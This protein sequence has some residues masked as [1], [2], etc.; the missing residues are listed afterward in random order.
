MSE[1]AP[2]VF[3]FYRFCLASVALVTIIIFRRQYFVFEKSKWLFLILLAILA[4]PLN[5]CLFLYGLNYTLPT[6]PALLYATTPIWVY[7]L[8]AWRREEKM[9]RGKTLGIFIA[10][11]GVVAFFMEKGLSMKMDY[12]FGDSLIMLAVW[13]WAIY[14]VLGRPL[15]QQKGVIAVTSTTLIL[16]T[17]MY[18]PFGLYL[19]LVF[20]YSRVSWIGWSAVAYTALLTS[21]LSYTIWYWSIKNMEPSRT[22]IFVN[23]QPVLTAFLAYFLLGERLSAGSLFSGLVI[24]AGVYVVQKNQ[25]PS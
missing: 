16:G 12:L 15:V 4:V 23:L 13:A 18:F 2:L 21:V 14:T 17:L 9:T 22:A 6:H 20:D 10:L 24:L 25:A 1:F 11:A 5:Q 8:S 19:A 3:A 7:L